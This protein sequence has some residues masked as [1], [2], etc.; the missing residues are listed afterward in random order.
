MIPLVDQALQVSGMFLTNLILARTQSKEE[1]GAFVL[2]YSFFILITSVHNGAILEAYTVYGAG[3]FRHSFAE[4]SKLILRAN[5]R[6]GLGLGFALLM[7]GLSAR[8]AGYP[9]LAGSLVGLSFAALPALSSAVIRRGLYVADKI[10]VS[11]RMSAVY[12]VLL[13]GGLILLAVTNRLNGMSVFILLGV[14][15]WIVV[16]L[17][18]IAWADG[19]SGQT[20]LIQN[21]SYWR[22]HWRY[23]KWVLASTAVQQVT[24]QAYYWITA[25][26]LS[27]R[28]VADLRA[29]HLLVLPMDQVLSVLFLVFM[30]LLARA[31]DEAN[32]VQ[33]RHIWKTYWT[34]IV[35]V[36]AGFAFVLSN[37]GTMVARMVYGSKFENVIGLLPL[38]ALL[39]LLMGVGGAMNDALKA[40]QRPKSIFRAYVVGAVFTVL[41]GIPITA[42]FGLLGAVL[43]MIISA[44]TYMLAMMISFRQLLRIPWLRSP[45][46]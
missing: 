13:V 45:Q 36:T 10:A 28:E 46:T 15:W 26:V 14:A 4:Y 18:F 32:G 3:R 16:G 6:V 5:V 22:E 30:P 37:V 42:K 39:P 43:G 35:I 9:S 17:F 34:T 7:I 31:F 1:Y 11:A 25:A 44:L 33:F 19:A 29:L 21:P 8:A 38:L 2:C 23:S 40:G 12:S 27:S 20:F 41:V 24:L